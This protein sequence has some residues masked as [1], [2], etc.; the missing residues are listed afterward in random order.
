MPLDLGGSHL[1]LKHTV[2]CPIVHMQLIMQYRERRVIMY[3]YVR[4]LCGGEYTV[5]YD[6]HWYMFDYMVDY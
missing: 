6:Q 2:E 1:L 5:M 4:V 3:D